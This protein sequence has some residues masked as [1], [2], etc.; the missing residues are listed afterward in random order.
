[1]A[2]I[3]D[4]FDEQLHRRKVECLRRAQRLHIGRG[5]LKWRE[6]MHLLAFGPECFAARGQNVNLGGV[7]EYVFGQSRDCLD[8]VLAAIE[9]EQQSLLAQKCQNAR[10]WLVRNRHETQLRGE[11]T[12]EEPWVFEGREVEEVNGSLKITQHS[13]RKCQGDGRLADPA[14]PDDRDETLLFQSDGELT[15]ALG[16]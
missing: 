3:S 9:H 5:A 12:G 1:M 8:D 11:H 13:V 6:M 14:C 4:L 2:A 16:S 10:Q 7:T 15:G